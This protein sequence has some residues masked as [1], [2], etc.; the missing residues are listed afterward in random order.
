MDLTK[1]L[2]VT[3]RPG[4]FKV[5]AQAKNGLIVESIIDKKRMPIHSSQKVSTLADI[6]MFTT[7]EDI[8]LKE[9]LKKLHAYT[10][11]EPTISPNE[12]DKKLT[13]Y[14]EEVLPEFDKE[15]VY[16]SD[17]R[18]LFKWY[19]LL[20]SNN[21]INFD[22]K[23]EEDS[24]TKVKKEKSKEKEEKKPVKKVSKKEDPKE[25]EAESKSKPATKKAAVKKTDENK[26]DKPAPKKATAKKK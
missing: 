17:I 11:G 7:D 24:A 1:I 9:V 14:F 8:K 5:V 4:L 18:K 16:A 19:N 26:E 2:S 25:A 12:D 20:L 23:T 21:L 13:T 3:G 6:T 15:R 22:E 10:K